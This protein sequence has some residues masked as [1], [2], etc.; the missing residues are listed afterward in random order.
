MVDAGGKA[1][2]RV[3]KSTRDRWMHA[4][5]VEDATILWCKWFEGPSIPRSS[6]RITAAKKYYNTFKNA[7][8]PSASSS[9]Y[10]WNGK[11]TAN[12]SKVIQIA[13]SG[14]SFGTG[15]GLCQAWVRAVYR[16]A[17]MGDASAYCARA[18]WEKWGVSSSKNNIPPGAAV[19]AGGISR[20][21]SAPGKRYGHVGIYLGNGKVASQVGRIEV[22]DLDSWGK[23]Y[24]GWLGWGWQGGKDLTK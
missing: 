7:T 16:N 9:N 10:T 13:Q 6:V 2:F 5:T 15:S 12:Q 1:V 8:M 22:I 21:P 20:D 4:S 3:P 24:G 17:G 18:A 19:Y 14:N 23:K 11:V